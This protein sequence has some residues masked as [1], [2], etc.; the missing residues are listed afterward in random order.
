MEKIELKDA[1][2]HVSLRTELA[3]YVGI[4]VREESGIFPESCCG[5]K[6]PAPEVYDPNE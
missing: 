1:Y 6:F 5:K 4:K 2:F 3:D